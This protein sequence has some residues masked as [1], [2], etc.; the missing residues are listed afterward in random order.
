ML[1]RAA[2]Q[3]TI[4][5]GFKGPDATVCGGAVT[6]LLALSYATRLLGFGRCDVLLCAAAEEF[7]PRRADG[8]HGKEE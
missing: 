8:A 4:W 5:Y 6:G 7:S 1:N 2:G 3:S